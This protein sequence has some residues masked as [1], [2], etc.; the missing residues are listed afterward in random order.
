MPQCSCH[1]QDEH[2]PGGKQ[3]VMRDGWWGGKPQKMTFNLGNI[4]NGLRQETVT[5]TLVSFS[6]ESMQKHYR[7]VRHYMFT[8]LEGVPGGSELEEL[9]KNQIK[10]H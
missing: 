10:S 8:Y 6:L 3:P 9:V 2:N 7:R 5:P 4:P 1:L